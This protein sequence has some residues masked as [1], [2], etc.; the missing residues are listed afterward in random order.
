MLENYADA[1]VDELANKLDGLESVTVWGGSSSDR[2]RELLREKESG[3]LPFVFVSDRWDVAQDNREYTV[4]NGSGEMATKPYDE[5]AVPIL[6]EPFL[7]VCGETQDEVREIVDA[8]RSRFADGVM[9]KVFIDNQ[10]D[11]A[12]PLLIR[13]SSSEVEIE[14]CGGLSKN[15][16]PI[17]CFGANVYFHPA[18]TPK[19]LFTSTIDFKDPKR[20]RDI[21]YR[22]V[23]IAQWC[24]MVA[25]PRR[26]KCW[27]QDYNS[28]VDPSFE[29][30]NY[31]DDIVALRRMSKKGDVP[32]REA[33]ES[34][35]KNLIPVCHD[36]YDRYTSGE[37]YLV[38]ALYITDKAN[39]IDQL[40]NQICKYLELP[41]HEDMQIQRIRQ[42]REAEAFKYYL[43]YMDE[44]TSLLMH[45]VYCKYRQHL[46]EKERHDIKLGQRMRSMVSDTAKPKPQAYCEEQSCE[47]VS[48]GVSLGGSVIGSIL[49]NAIGNYGVRKE[50]RNQ[51][52]LMEEEAREA[53]RE[54]ERERR[55]RATQSQ[56]EWDAVKKANDE[57]KRK[58]EPLL[59]LPPRYY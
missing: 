45:D 47:P 43:Q 36:L 31:S 13:V 11:D 44:D 3:L 38:T 53:K 12:I 6:Y 35:M 51:T 14:P 42:P 54:R 52:R 19:P 55:E 46:Q 29:S 59:P 22:F 32:S 8:L 15:A 20:D 58:G 9:C 18:A 25:N 28:V 30:S 33:F 40:K 50:L 7:V 2:L 57:R 49:G 4:M 34:C 23:Q 16:F 5:A 48:S 56:R 17:E 39:R 37:S 1:I 21:Q 26:I 24:N 41:E 27:L 10:K